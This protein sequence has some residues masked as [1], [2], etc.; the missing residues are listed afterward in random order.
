MDGANDGGCKLFSCELSLRYCIS[1]RLVRPFCRI[2]PCG[3]CRGLCRKAFPSQSAGE[4]YVVVVFSY[5][6]GRSTTL[7]AATS[8]TSTAATAP[9]GRGVG[10]INMVARKLIFRHSRNFRV[11]LVCS[12][13][14]CNSRC[15][16]LIP[17][18]SC[19]TP[20]ASAEFCIFVS[21]SSTL[22]RSV[23]GSPSSSKIV[24]IFC[25]ESKILRQGRSFGFVMKRL[26][27]TLDIGDPPGGVT[28]TRIVSPQR[29]HVAPPIPVTSNTLD[30]GFGIFALQES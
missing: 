23:K 27:D 12:N 16:K 29:S 2:V 11:Q 19:A 5:P 9:S 3:F 4:W 8:T 18:L 22:A 20:A 15:V 24:N 17:E 30:P 26:L 25:N 1:S 7:I 14:E 13:S 21:S 6:R 28:F 10:R